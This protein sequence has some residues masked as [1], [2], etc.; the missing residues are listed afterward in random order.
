VD[1]GD[2][3]A[4]LTARL[5]PVMKFGWPLILPD[6]PDVRCFVVATQ[7]IRLSVV[8]LCQIQLSAGARTPRSAGR[9]GPER[10]RDRSRSWPPIEPLAQDYGFL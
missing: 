5:G 8:E 9:I 3:I 4:I 10:R 1:D 6:K 7:D 2:D